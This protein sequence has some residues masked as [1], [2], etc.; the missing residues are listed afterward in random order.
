MIAKLPLV[1]L[2][3]TVSGL[4]QTVTNV[5]DVLVHPENFYERRVDLVGIAR[6]PGGFYLFGDAASATNLDLSKALLIRQNWHVGA[7][8][9]DLD[10]QWVRIRGTMSRIERPG[11][12]PGVGLLLERVDLFRNRNPPRIRDTTIFLIFQNHTNQHVRM[13]LLL[14]ANGPGR[15]WF[16]IRPHE[17]EETIVEEGGR[18]IVAGNKRRE[19]SFKGLATDDEYSP[20]WSS[21]RKLYFR[22]TEDRIDPVVASESQN[23]GKIGK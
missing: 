22:I 11:W 23:W 7:S 2:L 18:A 19:I 16:D 3:G 5:S 20:T 14:P 10:R 8:H 17:V 6:V 21:K 4:S 9:R 13:E 12:D 1:F 15:Q